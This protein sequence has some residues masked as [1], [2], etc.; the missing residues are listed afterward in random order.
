MRLYERMLYMYHIYALGAHMIIAPVS[1]SIMM[2]ANAKLLQH[3]SIV[4]LLPRLATTMTRDDDESENLNEYICEC[5]SCDAL[6]LS[7]IRDSA[8]SLRLLLHL[9]HHLR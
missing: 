8:S 5:S 9:R 2:D 6:R 3:I 7:S 1:M 4:V